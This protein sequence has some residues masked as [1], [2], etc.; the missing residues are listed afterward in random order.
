MKFDFCGLIQ[1][2]KAY[3]VSIMH[4]TLIFVCIYYFFHIHKLVV[5][6]RHK[7]FY[8]TAFA[9]KKIR[10]EH[11]VSD[12]NLFILGVTHLNL[13]KERCIKEIKRDPECVTFLYKV[14]SEV[15]AGNIV[16]SCAR[17]Y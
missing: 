15:K 3:S 9:L 10:T 7:R 13:S 8:S 1:F 12:H 14:I 5:C 6:S 4:N 17:L 16:I 2:M 11:S